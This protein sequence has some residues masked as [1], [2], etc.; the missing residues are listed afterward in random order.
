[1]LKANNPSLF[2][3]FSAGSFAVNTAG[4]KFSKIAFDHAQEQRIRVIKSSAG[5]IDSVNN[6]DDAFLK[7]L[8]FLYQKFMNS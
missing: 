7:P 6:E 2:A 8:N 1:M 4:V 3:E 5:Y